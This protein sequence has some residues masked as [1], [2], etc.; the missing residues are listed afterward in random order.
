MLP[1][2]LSFSALSDG[3]KGSPAMQATE[4]HKVASQT[5]EICTFPRDS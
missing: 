2:E 4:G 1:S 3:I 5:P